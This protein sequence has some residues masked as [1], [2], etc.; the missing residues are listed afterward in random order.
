MMQAILDLAK[1]GKDAEGIADAM[2][3]PAS[4]V[5]IIMDSSTFRARLANKSA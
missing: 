2:N 4:T 5:R 3:I 1:T